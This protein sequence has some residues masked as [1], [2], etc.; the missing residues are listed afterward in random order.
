MNIIHV[1]DLCL[2]L[3]DI[4]T[5]LTRG[6]SMTKS[7][8]YVTFFLPSGAIISVDNVLCLKLCIVL[9]MLLLVSTFIL[10]FCANCKQTAS[11]VNF[12]EK[13]YAYLIN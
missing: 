1:F 2:P 4:H 7:L 3:I 6:Q 9:C 13:Y 8:A 12:N 5:V 10:D 11:L